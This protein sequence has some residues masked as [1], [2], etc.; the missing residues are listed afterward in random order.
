LTQSDEKPKQTRK[1]KELLPTD[2]VKCNIN[3]DYKT[4]HGC[5]KAQ[6][7]FKCTRLEQPNPNKL[8]TVTEFFIKYPKESVKRKDVSK[9]KPNVLQQ[10]ERTYAEVE[11]IHN[12][13]NYKG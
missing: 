4:T 3:G 5:A 10:L 2:E 1:K 9:N 6:Y 12:P 7:I 11:M 8:G 13:N